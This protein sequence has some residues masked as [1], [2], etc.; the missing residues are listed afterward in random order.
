M[1]R[2]LASKAQQTLSR[3]VAGRSRSFASVAANTPLPQQSNLGAAVR[4]EPF[5]L[6]DVVQGKNEKEIDALP[7]FTLSRK[8][9][10]LPRQDPRVELPQ[11]FAGL[12][13]LLKRMTIQQYDAN[14][15]KSGT[16][17]LG[18][19]QFGDAVKHELAIGGIE[20]KAVDEAI[21]SGNQ[22]LLSAL[23]RDYCFAT[24][25]YLLEPTDQSYRKTGLYSPG[26]DRLPAQLAVPLKKL[27]DA[28]G[29]Q[30]FMEYA[31][32]YALVNYK[33]R[34][35]NFTGGEAGRYSF[36]NMDLIRSFQDAYGS[37]RGFILVHIVMVSF[38][39]RA[40]SATEDS[41]IAAAE[42]N[43]PAFE[44]AMSRLLDTYR[45][46]NKAMDTMWG[47]SLPQDYNNFRSFIFG[48]APK[49]GN[50]MFPNGVVYEGVGNEPLYYRGE[51]GANDSLVPLL[52]NLLEITA[53]LPNND[54]TRTLRDFRSYRPKNQR[55]YLSTLESRATMAGVKDFALNGSGSAKAKGLYLLMIDQVREFR[56]RHWLFAREYIIKNTNFEYATG[57]SK[58]L[59]YL[60]HNLSVVLSFLDESYASFSSVDE[61]QLKAKGEIKLLEQVHEAGSRAGAQHRMLQREVER[62]KK[63]AEERVKG[64]SPE[65]KEFKGRGML[66]EPKPLQRGW[67]GADGVG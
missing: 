22:H 39:G 26:R 13:S 58:M 18:H 64:L 63:D 54:L 33:F 56:N 21:A 12:D 47:R 35:P 59:H 67:V 40:L 9:G 2:S 27:A 65:E 55:D 10:F 51:S 62:L 37:E 11:Q 5:L 50:P 53:A 38:S 1:S 66:G 8:A 30:P 17:L 4:T 49:E 42:R 19:G 44:E 48:T 57:G 6:E 60:P 36:D 41:L 14:G 43:V 31:S 20:M 16:G 46:I 32:S 52:D 61:G 28:L 23:F 34:D 24:S 29:H 7:Q 3:S 25:A 15:N 45:S